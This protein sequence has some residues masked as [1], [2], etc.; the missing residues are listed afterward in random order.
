MKTINIP[1]EIHS[2]AV[3]AKELTDRKHKISAK[4]IDEYETMN[5]DEIQRLTKL[6]G[7]YVVSVLTKK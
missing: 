6:V 4:N 7:E 2:S 3:R 1:D 5:F